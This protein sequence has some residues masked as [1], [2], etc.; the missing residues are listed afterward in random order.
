MK[1]HV[2]PK[3]A[4]AINNLKTVNK[5][6]ALLETKHSYEEIKSVLLSKNQP[7]RKA[8]SD[9]QV[10]Y[11]AFMSW[12][13][14]K[15][16][17]SG[18]T[19]ESP[20]WLTK[21]WVLVMLC[22]RVKL[23]KLISKTESLYS[24]E[25]KKVMESIQTYTETSLRPILKQ[26]LGL[27]CVCFPLSVLSAWAFSADNKIFRV[28]GSVGIFILIFISLSFFHRE[29]QLRSE[30]GEKA[31]SR[32]TARQ[33]TIR[34]IQTKAQTLFEQLKQ[35]VAEV[36]TELNEKQTDTICNISRLNITSSSKG[37]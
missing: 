19:N 6:E 18:G 29:M 9:K 1:D 5:L 24:T 21:K 34:S 22:S 20:I 23:K 14:S 15:L 32:I 28:L 17:E 12:M 33:R 8:K 27:A 31:Q 16:L 3:L 4:S 30:I 10:N 26:H 36:E 2:D 25:L 13:I 37:S 11:D 7:N 35:T